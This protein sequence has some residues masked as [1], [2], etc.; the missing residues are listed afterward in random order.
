MVTTSFNGKPTS[1]EPDTIKA[2]ST[3]TITGEVRND[4]GTKLT[5]FNGSVYPTVFD[6][7]SVINTLGDNGSIATQFS[8]RKNIIYKGKVDVKN[9]EFS[10]TFLCPKDISY[11]YGI[12]KISYYAKSAESDAN[13]DD[14]NIIVGGYNNGATPDTLGPLIQLYMN[15][16]Y[17]VPGG[18]TNQDP[19][20]LAFVS[21]E[22]G[23]NTVG[24]GIGHDITAI[25]DGNT[26]EALI[27]NDYYVS[28]DNT[29]KS[30]VINY[31]MSGLSDGEHSI[32]LK[33]WDVYNNSSEAKIDFIVASTASFALS[34]LMNFPNPFR[35]NTTFSF[36][37]NQPNTAMDVDLRIYSLYGGLVKTIRRTVMTNGYK[38]QT[39]TW[40][41]RCDNGAILGSGTYLYRLQV[42]LPDGASVTRSSKLVFIR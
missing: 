33:V 20:L 32:I 41:G 15:D 26:K 17:F 5:D 37:Y 8:L 25:L 40:D 16:Q 18:I 31:P 27:L 28:D 22:S 38:A 36:E 14:E 2:L 13:G 9:G 39:I 23:I 7:T 24:N 34:K 42:S 19:N 1:S 11:V 6:K 29:Y 12:G 21:D 10:F 30:G 3:I 4:S 35:D